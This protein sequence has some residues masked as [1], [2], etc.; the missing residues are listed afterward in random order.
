MR[1][2]VFGTGGVG[3]YFGGRLAQAGHSVAFI[4][5]GSH[6][7]AIRREGLRVLSATG[8][9]VVRPAEA[10]DDPE[11]AGPVEVVLVCVKAWQVAEAARSLQPM[12][13]REGFVVPLQNGV[14]AADAIAAV[15]GEQRV[16]AGLCRILSH[17]ASPGTIRH[18]GV[19]PSIE[20]GER[21]NRRSARSDRL[22]AAFQEASGV[23]AAIPDDI[24]AAVWE[25]FLFIASFGGVGAF[26][27]APAG[28]LR[29]RPETRDMLRRAMQEIFAL[30]RARRIQIRADA[31]ERAMQIIDALPADAV[32]SMQRDLLEGRP[33]ELESLAGA[34]VRLARAAGVPAP[35]NELLDRG[36]RPR[37]ER[38]WKEA[39]R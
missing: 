8:D 3:G 7:D 39:C 22:L 21:D 19:A 32:A 4:A 38:A 13:G 26:T 18:A 2:G 33:C 9:F 6:L 31:V 23:T 16:L 24:E 12:L 30:A 10:T 37:A 1:I 15:V 11:A 35:M 29:G 5:R 34:V 14:E 25:K 27:G 28:V 20:F 36:L 17:I